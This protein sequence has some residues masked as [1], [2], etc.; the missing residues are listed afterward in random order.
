[1][2]HL[3]TRGRSLR[4]EQVSGGSRV[5]IQRWEFLF[6]C[7]QDVQYNNTHNFPR[8]SF[9]ICTLFAFP[10]SIRLGYSNISLL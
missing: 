1:V 3:R 10:L 2:H 4:L 5:Q 6:S 7:R 8:L 9:D